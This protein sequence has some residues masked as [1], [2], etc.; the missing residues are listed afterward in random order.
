MEN[1]SNP[2]ITDLRQSSDYGKYIE[3]LGWKVV[4]NNP[5]IFIRKLWVLGSIAKIQRFK[6]LNWQEVRQVL[7]KHHVWMTKAEPDFQSSIPNS[8]FKQDTWP[9]LAT[10]TLRI[11]LSPDLSAIFNQFK[12]DCRYTLRKLQT[13][14][15]QIQLNLFDDF[16][17]IWQTS[18]RLKKLWIPPK[19]DYDSL[20]RCFGKNCFCITINNLAG[21]LVLI[22]DSVAYYYYSGALPEGKKL[23]L[24]YL[25]IW[26]CIKESKKRKCKIWDFEGI[27]DYRWPNR[28][29]LGF[30]HFKKS[31]GG[32]EVSFPGSF[33]KW[34]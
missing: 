12:K 17:E 28:G 33:T 31:F 15:H 34:F 14:N 24:P 7:K 18:A 10:K 22:H 25:V 11:S 5:Q 30:S 13:T 16:Y 26:E 32:Y 3:S 6:D 1:T 20:I 21:A 2:E 27:Y 8:Q 29:W 4:G 9:M 23:N 19:K